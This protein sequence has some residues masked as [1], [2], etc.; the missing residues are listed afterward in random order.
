ARTSAIANRT[1]GGHEREDGLHRP[2]SRF[3]SECKSGK[4][5][6]SM[7]AIPPSPAFHTK[8]RFP[9]G[10]ELQPSGQTQIRV[11]APACN[12]VEV[13]LVGNPKTS[14]LMCEEDGY[15]SGLLDAGRG[16][17]YR[18]RL[19]GQSTLY[20]DP[21]SRF[22]PEGPHGPSEVVDPTA[23]QWSDAAWPGVSPQ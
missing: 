9:I 20:P 6:S 18:F 3:L 8:R 1:V 17:S 2:P 19:D 4:R 14:C 5:I 10:A 7:T 21:A 15:F 11:L 12:Q 23:F 13:V 16:A 22:Q